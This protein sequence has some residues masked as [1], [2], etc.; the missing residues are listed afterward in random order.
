MGKLP[1]HGMDYWSYFNSPGGLAKLASSEFAIGSDLRFGLKEL[2]TVD[3]LG[4]WK[5]KAGTLG[6]GIS[7]SGRK[8]NLI[9]FI[10][11]LSNQV[12]FSV[13]WR[14]Y[15]SNFHS[16]YAN[17]F[18]ESTPPA[19]EQDVYL[20]IQIKEEQ[21]DRK[22][23]DTGEPSLPYQIGLINK[24]NGLLS[25]EYQVSKSFFFGREFSLAE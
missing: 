25:L 17:A 5:F 21:K 13:L 3:L 14:K 16:F 2:S 15:D 12:Y 9:G 18:A 22:V 11:S 20:G 10:S 8:G 1:V 4:A 23:S 24:I 19:N 7:Q 6:F